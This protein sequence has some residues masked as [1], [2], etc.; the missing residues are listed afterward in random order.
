M[1]HKIR[2]CAIMNSG[3]NYGPKYILLSTSNV[4]K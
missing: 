2:S 4:Y 3:A 1:A